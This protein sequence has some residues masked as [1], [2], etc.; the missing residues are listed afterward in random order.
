MDINKNLKV[1]INDNDRNSVK[2]LILGG[3]RLFLEWRVK[4]VSVTTSPLARK[5]GLFR[6]TALLNTITT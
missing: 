2:L 5:N 4:V 3:S 1:I 6:Q